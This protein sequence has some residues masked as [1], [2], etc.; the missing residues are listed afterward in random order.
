MNTK[1]FIV[2]QSMRADQKVIDA[3]LRAVFDRVKLLLN[4]KGREYSNDANRLENFLETARI[5]DITPEEALYNYMLKHIVSIRKF[6]GEASKVTRPI[7]QW[8]E[9]IGDIEAYLVLLRVIVH[10]RQT[11]E[12]EMQRELEQRKFDEREITENDRSN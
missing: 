6:I 10:I 5:E 3:H 4:S 11:V 7:A 1:E 12:N 2:L 9:K 8:D